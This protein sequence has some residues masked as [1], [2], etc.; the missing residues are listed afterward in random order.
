MI[1]WGDVVTKYHNLGLWH[2]TRF[3]ATIWTVKDPAELARDV[4]Q[5][6]WLKLWKADKFTKGLFITAVINLCITHAGRT[7][8]IE[9]VR[10]GHGKRTGPKGDLTKLTS[11][12]P[13]QIFG[14][15]IGEVTSVDEIES[16]SCGDE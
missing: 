10:K 16:P 5:E 1:D 2:A 13:V 9:V 3:L 7:K 6:A 11:T 4:V 12:F 8:P 15:L 14:G